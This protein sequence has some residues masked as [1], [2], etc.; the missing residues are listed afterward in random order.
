MQTS[1]APTPTLDPPPPAGAGVQPAS[2]LTAGTAPKSFPQTGA[3]IEDS[4]PEVYWF[5]ITMPLTGLLIIIVISGF[6]W[7]ERRT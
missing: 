4:G 5:F 1:P 3:A 7:I 2:V 6:I